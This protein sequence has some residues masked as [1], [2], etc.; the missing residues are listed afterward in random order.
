MTRG[1]HLTGPKRQIALQAMLAGPYRSVA[2]TKLVFD[3]MGPRHYKAV[4]RWLRDTGCVY[5]R[6]SRQWSLPN[7]DPS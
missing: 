4:M 1:L 5:D 7:G 2:L 3:S 6:H